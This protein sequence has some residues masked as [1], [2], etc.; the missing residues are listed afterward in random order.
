MGQ[1][2]NKDS[3]SLAGALL[4]ET[5]TLHW[6]LNVCVSVSLWWRRCATRLWL[7]TLLTLTARTRPTS[8]EAG[9]ASLAAHSV[10][11][12]KGHSDS[13]QLSFSGNF[14]HR[15]QAE[16]NRQF[17]YQKAKRYS[18]CGFTNNRRW[19]CWWPPRQGGK[20]NLRKDENCFIMLM[21]RRRMKRSI[22]LK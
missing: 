2:G 11:W 16:D 14:N 13:S 19:N 15:R 1:L 10:H 20:L 3:S 5:L 18:V 7:R 21:K 8:W 17:D 9:A 12:C 6:D 22:F 4:P